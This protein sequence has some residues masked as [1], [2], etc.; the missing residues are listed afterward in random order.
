MKKGCVRFVSLVSLCVAVLCAVSCGVSYNSVKR[1]QK[2]EEGVDHP[3]TKEELIEALRKYDA[4]AL[5]LV[6]T[7][8]QEG[9]WYK[10][11]GTRY[12]DERMYGEALKC[13]QKAV[14]F[15]PDN[16]NLFYYVG[17]C[18]TYMANASL[19][20]S[21]TGGGEAAV[22]KM[23]YYN[24][25]EQAFLR[26]LE[27]EPKYY[28]ALYGIG[29]LYVYELDRNE[30]A[31]PYLERFLS[32]QSKDTNGMFA[33]ARAYYST[34]QFEKAVALYDQIIKLKPNAEKVADAEANKKK[35]LDIM[36]SQ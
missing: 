31:I 8:S 18:A 12:L 28:R 14:T 21:A 34:Y 26:S 23:R 6:T 20:Y 24:L 4:R 32:V 29:V 15:Y 35:T 33:L 13:F 9:I 2:M 3:T 17:A 10:I 19:D 30:E 11:L 27:I 7:Q 25:A 5:D 22:Q 16:A 36:Y 1:M